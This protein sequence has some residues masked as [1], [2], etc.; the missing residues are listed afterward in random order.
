VQAYKEQ[1]AKAKQARKRAAQ[2][3]A[4]EAEEVTR[5]QYFTLAWF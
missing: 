2:A 5:F 3:E 1:D 4:K